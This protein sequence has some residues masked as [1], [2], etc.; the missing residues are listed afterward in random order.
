MPRLKERQRPTDARRAGGNIYTRSRDDVNAFSHLSRSLA[1]IHIS[2]LPGSRRRKTSE[3]SRLQSG[4]GSTELTHPPTSAPHP[5][6]YRFFVASAG[7]SVFL[8]APTPGL[9]RLHMV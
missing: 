5:F 9:C 6:G 1:S 4:I 3:P 2:A 8:H 7:L